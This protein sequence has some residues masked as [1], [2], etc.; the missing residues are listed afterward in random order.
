MSLRVGRSCSGWPARGQ[1]CCID[2]LRGLRA[3]ARDSTLLHEAH[4]DACGFCAATTCL[5]A[6]RAQARLRASGNLG[7][8]GHLAAAHPIL[9]LSQKYEDSSQ[10]Q[11]AHKYPQ[12]CT[13]ARNSYEGILLRTHACA[14]YFIAART[15]PGRTFRLSS[16]L[17]VRRDPPEFHSVEIIIACMW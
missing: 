13:Q 4:R 15:F 10:H 7:G 3:T 1:S 11:P 2:Q 9:R 8:E 12:R 6:A 17:F 5:Q 16:T 14:Q